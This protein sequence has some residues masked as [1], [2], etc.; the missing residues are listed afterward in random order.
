[1]LFQPVNSVDVVPYVYHDKRREEGRSNKILD[2]NHL[3]HDHLEWTGKSNC[4]ACYLL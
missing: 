2:C 3:E 1:M 4:V